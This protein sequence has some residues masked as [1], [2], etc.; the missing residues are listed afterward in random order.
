[1]KYRPVTL[2]RFDIRIQKL[3]DLVRIIHTEVQH[4]S[5]DR[6]LIASFQARI[7]RQLLIGILLF[8][9]PFIEDGISP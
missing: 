6:F 4:E 2:I 8:Q 7:D 5:F 3:L 1:M 9:D